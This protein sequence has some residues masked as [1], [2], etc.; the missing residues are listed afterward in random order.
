MNKTFLLMLASL[1][2]CGTGMAQDDGGQQQRFWTV[3]GY[4][5]Y[6]VTNEG[7]AV[8][9]SF[10]WNTPYFIWDS[11]TGDL[12]EIGGVTAG[13]N[14]GG[15]GRFTEDGKTVGAVMRSDEIR[16][17]TSWQRIQLDGVDCNFREIVQLP[18]TT[19]MFAIGASDDLQSGRMLRST[20]FGKTW[21]LSAIAV[22]NPDGPSSDNGWKGGLE[23]IGWQSYFNG[24]TGGHNGCLYYTKN[25]GTQW[26]WLDIHPAGN[27]DEVATY[28]AVDFIPV[29]ENYVYKYG[30]VGL[31]KAGGTGAVWYTTDG[32]TTFAEAAGVGGVP[33]GISHT[34]E[35][36]YM[37]TRNGLIQKSEDYGATWTTVLDINTGVNPLADT[38][39]QLLNRIR[40][41]D[42]NNGMAF[43]TGVVYV[44]T[45][46]GN[47]WTAVAVADGTE[48]VSWNDAVYNDGKVTVVGSAGNMY[49]TADM[50]GTWRKV[51]VESGLGTDLLGVYATDRGMNAC[52]DGATFF[53]RG[54]SEYVSGYTAALY[55]VDTETWTPL[56]GT[57]YFSSETASSGWDIS[58]DGSTVV[59]GVYNYEQ[60]NASSAVRC[61]A[62][63]WV[64][65]EL[66]VLGN[67]FADMNR[68]SQ[69]R[70]VSYDG[71]V[72]VGYQ[73]HHGPWF[74]SVWRRN[75]SGGYD[76]SLMPEDPNITEA[77]IDM[78]NTP[79]G[80]A[81]MQ[82]KLL[83]QANA[84]SAD[85][86]IIGG[87]GNSQQYATDCAWIWSEEKGLKLLGGTSNMVFDMTNDG[88][89]VVTNTEVWTEETGLVGVNQYVTGHLGIDL[90]EYSIA[91]IYD[92]S[93]NG[94]YMTGVCMS[95]MDKYA[96]VIDLLGD[97]T[98]GIDNDIVQTKAA[99]YPNPV[100]S[101]LHVDLPFSGMKTRIS[102]YSTAG[103]MV[104]S[105]TT[106]ATS[107]TISVADLAEGVYILEVSAGGARKTFKLIVRH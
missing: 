92:L 27:T 103:A 86:K 6:S 2:C 34:G 17:S 72:A 52:G 47:N 16:V 7:Q 45:D 3:G 26:E 94:R 8:V 53:Y 89:M 30:A 18:G 93:P 82:A 38:G 9:S 73:D 91:S 97:G 80:R 85:G 43:G 39:G 44:T 98:T 1:A 84:V 68:P 77:D 67:K 13:N 75:A 56:P 63:A 79:E 32:A 4:T 59:G 37:V 71:S 65:G 33:V 78:S 62:A 24:L 54:A 22:V 41:F 83:G 101:E 64:D 70:R 36:Y 19:G 29:T 14:V 87:A 23:C 51:T 95:G 11:Q 81:D 55:D 102:L 40:F 74:A 58:G 46:G 88:S 66:V 107:N 28:W 15:V 100:A 105:I 60:L 21:R 99:V 104:K 57:G 5:A 10:N 69:S 96:Y 12:K 42:C 49:E 50:G 31:E 20:D 106:N 48:G 25:G 35:V 76:Q 90:G 61:D